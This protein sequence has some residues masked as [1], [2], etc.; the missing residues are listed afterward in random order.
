MSSQARQKIWSEHS[1]HLTIAKEVPQRSQG[2][3]DP[4]PDPLVS[5]CQKLPT[6]LRL[7]ICF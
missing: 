4:C 5:F 2:G 7:L 6:A 3:P 1:R